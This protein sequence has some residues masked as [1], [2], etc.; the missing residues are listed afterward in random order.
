MKT[1]T[2]EGCETGSP[3]YA[4]GMC[5]IHYARNHRREHPEYYRQVDQKRLAYKRALDQKRYSR[6]RDC[7]YFKQMRDK[8]IHRRRKDDRERWASGQKKT[9]QKAWIENNREHLRAYGRERYRKDPSKFMECVMRRYTHKGLATPKWLTADHKKQLRQIY[10]NRPEG[11]HV[12]HIVPIQGENV[13]GLHVPWNLQYLPA[14]ENIR[15]GNK[16]A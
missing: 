15:K 9:T 8:H 10:K 14:A 2:V 1:C 12:D 13:C 16:C 11:H 6:R 3:Y 5:S 7:G 4:K